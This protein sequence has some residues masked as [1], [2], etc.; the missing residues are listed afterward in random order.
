MR[1]IFLPVSAADYAA[2]EFSADFT[3]ADLCTPDTPPYAA[4]ATP[5]YR[6][7]IYATAA[8]CHS[9]DFADRHDAAT[10]APLVRIYGDSAYDLFDA[11]IFF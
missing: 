10:P 1:D 8:G 9:T 7:D 2:I 4:S 11:T 5:F 6:S 3:P